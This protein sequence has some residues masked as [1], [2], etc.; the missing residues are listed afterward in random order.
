MLWFPRNSAASFFCTPSS[1]S[2]M[3]FKSV[4]KIV[5]H[6]SEDSTRDPSQAA[7]QRSGLQEARNREARRTVIL[8]LRQGRRNEKPSE[9]RELAK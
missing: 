3:V 2:G 6:L 9:R 8:H 1:D 7:P 4:P 5:A